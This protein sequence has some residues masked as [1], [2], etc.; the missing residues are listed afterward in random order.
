MMM[1]PLLAVATPPAHAP[2]H[3]HRAK[4]KASAPA[5]AP[6]KPGIEISFDSERGI[7]V[8][9]G[10]PDIVFH[11]GHYYREH[12]GGWQISLSGDGGWRVAVESKIPGAVRDA[13]KK[14]HPGPAKKKHGKH[15]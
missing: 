8:A 9:V 13:R 10:F 15:R 14:S 5:P 1:V 4:H 3:G 2:A 12:D 11:D 6:K 7:R